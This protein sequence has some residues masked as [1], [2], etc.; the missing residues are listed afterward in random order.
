VIAPKFVSVYTEED[1]SVPPDLGTCP[2]D[3]DA[4]EDTFVEGIPKFLIYRA[5]VLSPLP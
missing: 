5:I 2:Y 3:F 1:V 4:I